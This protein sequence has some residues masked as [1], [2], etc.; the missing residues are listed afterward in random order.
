LAATCKWYCPYIAWTSTL[1]R[2]LWCFASCTAS[3]KLWSPVVVFTTLQ[4]AATKLL[5]DL[6]YH[7]ISITKLF[8][9]FGS[10]STCWTFKNCI[11]NIFLREQAWRLQTNHKHASLKKSAGLSGR[12][13]MH[14]PETI[15][16]SK[17]QLWVLLSERSRKSRWRSAN[18]LKN[19]ELHGENTLHRWN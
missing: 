10:I 12:E 13:A 15:R 14:V 9:I 17:R 3:T 4:G 19:H 7:K 6:V 18:C 8:P 1:Y 2:W 16:T 5:I 11:E